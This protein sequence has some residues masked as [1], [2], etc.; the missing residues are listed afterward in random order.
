[1]NF[2]TRETKLS[3]TYTT[4]IKINIQDK[5]LG[6]LNYSAILYFPTEELGASL[7]FEHAF[8]CGIRLS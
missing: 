3:T 6:F 8:K 1:V 5:V 7:A 2:K 4:Y